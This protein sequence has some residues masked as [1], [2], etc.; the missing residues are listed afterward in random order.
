[1]SKY[2]RSFTDLPQHPGY[3]VSSDGVVKRLRDGLILVPALK[4]YGVLAVNL[5][6]PDKTR[7]LVGVHTLVALAHVPNPSGHTT[8]EHIDG[9]RL[10]NN[11]DN[12]MWCVGRHADDEHKAVASPTGF[13][14]VTGYAGYFINE[15]GQVKRGSGTIVSCGID[16][17]GYT[18]HSLNGRTLWTHRLVATTFIQ[19]P[20]NKPLINHINGLPW[21]NRK[22]NLEWCTPKENVTHA[23]SMGLHNNRGENSGR[24]RITEADVAT[25]RR[26]CSEGE[27]R[28]A[29][30][31]KFGISRKY[32]TDIFL[33]RAWKHTT[34][35]KEQV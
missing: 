4:A 24:A 1:M 25:I 9:N 5:R 16:K 35:K 10:N 19:N 28:F 17:H 23:I 26:L 27:D 8:V 34:N 33:G 11:A 30:A 3:A 6:A 2:L 15:V 18:R 21:D 22:E 14:P 13:T 20:E 12:L 31:K 29:V 32:V 7:V